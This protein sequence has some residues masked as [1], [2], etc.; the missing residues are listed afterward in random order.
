VI[1]IHHETWKD[2]EAWAVKRQA[3]AFDAIMAANMP[4]DL[5]QYWRGELAAIRALLALP[6]EQAKT[7]QEKRDGG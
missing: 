6:A 1:D 3:R 5:T 2:I 4:H 7:Q